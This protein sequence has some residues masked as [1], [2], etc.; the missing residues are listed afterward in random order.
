MS[1]VSNPELESLSGLRNLDSIGQFLDI[2]GNGSLPS[3]NGLENLTYVGGEIRIQDNP[4]L[5]NLSAFGQLDSLKGNLILLDNPVLSSL[6][7][8]NNL[9]YIGGLE[10]TGQ[11]SIQNL[12]PLQNLKAVGG[13]LAIVGNTGL[14]DFSGLENLDTIGG[15]LQI[16]EISYLTTLKGLENID[17]NTI[18]ELIITESPMLSACGLDNLCEYL[19]TPANPATISGNA[20][21]C[22]SREEVEAACVTGSIG[23]KE[24]S[25]ISISPNPSNGI[26]HLTGLPSGEITIEVADSWGRVIIAERPDPPLV[27]L[28][29]QPAGMYVITIQTE[30]GLFARRLMKW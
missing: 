3:L 20:P 27:N 21:S 2:Y 7:G 1:I 30:H 10:I 14:S 29:K 5:A 19:A 15:Y 25:Q 23:L 4:A 16:S 6:E 17:P 12:T 9:T 13:S 22:S 18:S 24:E 8:L 26:F 28:A 11:E